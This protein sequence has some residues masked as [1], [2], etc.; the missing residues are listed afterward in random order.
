MGVSN[1]DKEAGVK[2]LETKY[3]VD[4]EESVERLLEDYYNI[5]SAAL[6][7]GDMA[8]IDLLVDI[9]SA[10]A[11]AEM[12]EEQRLVIQLMYFDLVPAETIA[13]EMGSSRSTVTRRR[14]AGLEAIRDI[15]IKW[16]YN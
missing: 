5:E 7:R 12:S 11:Q 9:E 16:E 10:F 14:R 2:R 1:Y 8:A 6:S 13:R 3:T 15:F 4:S